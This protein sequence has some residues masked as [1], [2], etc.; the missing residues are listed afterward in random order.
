MSMASRI[1]C[2]SLSNARDR[3]ISTRPSTEPI[4]ISPVIIL[5]RYFDSRGEQAI[6]NPFNMFFLFLFEP[7]PLMF[8]IFLNR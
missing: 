8:A 7:E 3:A 1:Y 4:R 2:N 5:I 6:S